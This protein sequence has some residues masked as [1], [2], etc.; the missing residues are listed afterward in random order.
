M[1]SSFESYKILVEVI[2]EESALKLSKYV[3]GDSFYIPKYETVTRLKRNED[4]R[5]DYHDGMTYKQLHL[6]YRLSERQIRNITAR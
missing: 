4:I 3:D 1:K 6:K 2:G 5:R